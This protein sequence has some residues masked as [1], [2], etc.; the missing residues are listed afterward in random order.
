MTR[1]VLLIAAALTTACSGWSLTPTTVCAT[2]E[3]ELAAGSPPLTCA[4]AEVA[5]TWLRHVSGRP[6]GQADRNL[7][8]LDLGA[9]YKVDPAEVRTDLEQLAAINTELERASGMT[10]AETRSTRAW[11]A[12]TANGPLDP[13]HYPEADRSIRR[14]VAVWAQ[15]DEEKLVLT[16]A[17]IEAWISFASLCREVQS[18]EPLKLSIANREALYRDMRVRFEMEPRTGQIGLVGLG[19]YWHDVEERWIAASYKEQQA[20]IAAATLPPPMTSRSMGYAAVI[21]EGDLRQQ[22]VTMHE[23]LGPFT[24]R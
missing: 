8:L 19:G 18:G 1:T 12:V 23:V 10:G 3:A 14:R 24:L 20:W 5:I 13:E 7:V 11:E 6:T 4:E 22:A 15:D 2:D 21:F 16:E 17:D 9:R